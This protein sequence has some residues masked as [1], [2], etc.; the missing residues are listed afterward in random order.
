M[1]FAKLDAHIN[2]QHPSNIWCNILRSLLLKFTVIHSHIF[3]IQMSER[4][5]AVAARLLTTVLYYRGYLVMLLLQ[6][7]CLQFC[8]VLGLLHIC[9]SEPK[10]GWCSTFGTIRKQT[11]PYSC[12]LCI[13]WIWM[14]IRWTLREVNSLSGPLVKWKGIET[15][16]EKFATSSS[17]D[18]GLFYLRKARF[19][20]CPP[21]RTM[22]VCMRVCVSQAKLLRV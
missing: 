2:C 7:T 11:I 8:V 6:L 4:E 10:E 17:R 13:I 1:S 16:Q 3:H 14:W 18:G 5:K 9:M 22:S 21:A 20:E 12:N 15:R 19:G